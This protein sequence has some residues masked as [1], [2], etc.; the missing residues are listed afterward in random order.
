VIKH[1]SYYETVRDTRFSHSCI[2]N[3]WS[4]RTMKDICHPDLILSPHSM[5][6]CRSCTADI[7]STRRARSRSTQPYDRTFAE[8]FAATAQW[9]TK[10]LTVSSDYSDSITARTTPT[11]TQYPPQTPQHHRPLCQKPTSASGTEPHTASH[12]LRL[13]IFPSIN[14]PYLSTLSPSFHTNTPS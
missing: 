10:K 11:S 3:C 6:A 4:S 8:Q 1:A 12:H 2:L 5:S 7:H 13:P 14:A 9:S